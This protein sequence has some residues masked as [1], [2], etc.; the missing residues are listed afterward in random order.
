MGTSTERPRYRTSIFW[1]VDTR[2]RFGPD[3]PMGLTGKARSLGGDFPKARSQGPVSAADAWS[4]SVDGA[5]YDNRVPVRQALERC[6]RYSGWLALV[7]TA[8]C[9]GGS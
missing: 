7:L 4:L 8:G 6:S 5:S 1:Q 9:G 3:Q 2:L